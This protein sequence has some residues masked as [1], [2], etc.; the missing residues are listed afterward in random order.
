MLFFITEYRAYIFVI[1]W[2]EFRCARVTEKSAKE[3]CGH[4]QNKEV[5]SLQFYRSSVRPD[6]IGYFI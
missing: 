1:E 5:F 6:I 4:R 2:K 3:N